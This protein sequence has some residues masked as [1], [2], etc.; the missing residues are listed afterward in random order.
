MI[1]AIHFLRVKSEVPF[2]STR[3][4]AGSSGSQSLRPKMTIINRAY[5]AFNLLR[6]LVNTYNFAAVSWRESSVGASSTLVLS[7]DNCSA[8]AA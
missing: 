2:V 4:S 5:I 7:I 3:L 1:D 6:P 8:K